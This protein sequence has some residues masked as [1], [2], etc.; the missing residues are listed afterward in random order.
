MQ[1]IINI[2]LLFFIFIGQNI[3]AKVPDQFVE[4]ID[5]EISTISVICDYDLSPEEEN[6]ILQNYVDSMAEIY[7][8]ADFSAHDEVIDIIKNK[9]H[10]K[11]KHPKKN[12]QDVLHFFFEG[13][14]VPIIKTNEINQEH[15]EA[16]AYIVPGVHRYREHPYF[17]SFDGP[18]MHFE[19]ER[20]MLFV[21]YLGSGFNACPT[22]SL[23]GAGNFLLRFVE[24]FAKGQHITRIHLWD[25][26]T[27]PSIDYL[28]QAKLKDLYTF[29]YGRTW[30]N[31]NGY[32]S[33]NGQ[34]ADLMRG[35]YLRNFDMME[36][37]RAFDD[38]VENFS[39]IE[40][41][42]IEKHPDMEAFIDDYYSNIDENYSSLFEMIGR[43]RKEVSSSVYLGPFFLWLWENNPSNY[44]CLL[45]M[46]LPQ[47]SPECMF[48]K[49][50]GWMAAMK[51]KPSA[52]AKIIR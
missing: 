14:E 46:V 37:L 18:C 26:A 44:V 13:V 36:I 32:Y 47:P 22:P 11:Y 23:Q 10:E 20:D 4:H 3:L 17:S 30:Y 35:Q 19:I 8:Y 25:D 6:L 48:P 34:D 43:Y 50:Y 45:P 28:F 51:Q 52:L 24:E 39:E 1:M 41:A 15:P 7:K 27:V 21:Q 29:K 12:K 31:K 38:I 9:L 40:K 5:R 16:E 49:E 42:L 33:I 2:F